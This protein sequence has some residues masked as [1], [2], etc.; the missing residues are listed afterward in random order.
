MALIVVSGCATAGPAG[1]AK[2]LLPP[3]AEPTAVEAPPVMAGTGMATTPPEPFIEG[4]AAAANLIAVP[5]HGLWCGVSA[6]VAGVFY[7]YFFPGDYAEDMKNYIAKNCAGPYFVTPAEIARPPAPMPV[8]PL[9][10]FRTGTVPVA[11]AVRQAA[12]PR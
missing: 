2:P 1:E 3:V 4:A 11:A 7:A 5:M 9:R 10:I 12:Q 6:V 8:R